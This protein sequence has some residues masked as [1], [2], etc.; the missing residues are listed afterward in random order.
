M[1]MQPKIHGVSAGDVHC[2]V[3]SPPY[4]KV[5][6]Y[7]VAGQWGMEDSPEEY[8]ERLVTLMREIRRVLHKQGTVWINIGDGYGQSKINIA[9]EL[10][11]SGKRRGHD[12]YVNRRRRRG[13]LV[14]IPHMLGL[15]LTADGWIWR[16][17]IIWH[18]PL[19]PQA[20]ERRPNSHH[21]HVLFLT[22]GMDYFWN[23]N[24][25]WVSSVWKIAPL[26][27]QTQ[28]PAP[29]PIELAR[30]CI[31]LGSPEGGLV[32]DPFSGSG[33]TLAAA[34][35]FGRRAVGIDLAPEC[36]AGI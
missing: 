3:T 4:F 32:L 26:R 17:D 21:E 7:E 1:S 27:R 24:P 31:A 20:G 28:H 19:A 13:C 12:H 29:M 35:A 16:Q 18:K 23:D 30:R 6:D 34:K 15:A 5:I 8:V 11:R 36:P 14:G 2:V 22:K 9:S 10:A 33:T 25:M